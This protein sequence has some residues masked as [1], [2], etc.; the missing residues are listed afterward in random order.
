MTGAQLSSFPELDI[1]PGATLSSLSILRCH[2]DNGLD[3]SQCISPDNIF[4]KLLYY[5]N[6]S[7]IVVLHCIKA[8]Y[9]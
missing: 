9:G 2:L 6:Y 7:Q 5:N 4:Y 3:Q 1:N 8:K